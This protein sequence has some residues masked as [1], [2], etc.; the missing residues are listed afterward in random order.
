MNNAKKL[1]VSWGG[2]GEKHA[3]SL[4]RVGDILRMLQIG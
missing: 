2:G 1:V 4:V 3:S